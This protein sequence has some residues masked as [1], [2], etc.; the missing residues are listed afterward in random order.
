M[1]NAFLDTLSKFKHR[2]ITRDY[3]QLAE[4]HRANGDSTLRINYPLTKHSIVFDLGGYKGDWA[5]LIHEK[6]QSAILIFEPH[7]VYQALLAERFGMAG[8]IRLFPFGLGSGTRSEVL[9]DEA[10]GSSI[11]GRKSVNTVPVLIRSISDV[12]EEENIAGVDLIKINIEG[13]E[14]ELL[15]HLLDTNEILRFNNIQVQFHNFV[16][17]AVNRMEQIRRRLAA[18]H[19][20]TYSYRFVW[21]NWRIKDR[22]S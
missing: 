12:L 18:S 16:P 2:Y 20:Q 8:N 19:Y 3:M 15:E 22:Q 11:F 10:E 6:Y 7:P 14:Y 17:G 9:T 13:A 21:E 4:W 5:Q 1:R